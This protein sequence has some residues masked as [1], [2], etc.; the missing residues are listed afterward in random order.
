MISDEEF[1]KRWDKLEKGHDDL[2]K[3]VSLITTA[4]VAGICAFIGLITITVVITL[5]KQGGLQ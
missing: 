4:I 1:N 2:I 5:I 3:E